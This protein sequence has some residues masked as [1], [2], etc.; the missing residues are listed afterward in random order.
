M[1]STK[2]NGVRVSTLLE[3]LVSDLFNPSYRIPVQCFLDGDMAHAC[4]GGCSMPV[5]LARFEPNHVARP[6]LLNRATVSLNETEARRYNQRLA[7]RVGVPRR[8]RARLE[9]YMR[10]RHPSRRWRG[11][12]WVDADTTGEPVFGPGL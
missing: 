6:Y 8:A 3:L 4:R 10:G 9:C 7:E 5:L 11:M 1:R 2:A 12:Q